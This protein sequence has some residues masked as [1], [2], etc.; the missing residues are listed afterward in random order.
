MQ[1]RR[2]RRRA[3]HG[4][5]QPV[6]QGNLGRLAHG[7][8]EQQQPG[9]D[10][11]AAV[12]CQG[13][14]DFAGARRPDEDEYRDVQAQIGAAGVEEGAA[15]GIRGLGPLE[16]EADQQVA[17]QSDQLPGRQQQY[18]VAGQHQ[19]LHRGEEQGHDGTEPGQAR[20][21]LHVADRVGQH[22]RADGGHRHGQQR[23]QRLGGQAQWHFWQA[24]QKQRFGRAAGN[25]GQK[26]QTRPQTEHGTAQG[27]RGSAPA[28]HQDGRGGEQGEQHRQQH[29]AHPF[30]SRASSISTEPLARKRAIATPK[31]TAISTAMTV[32]TTSTNIC[33]A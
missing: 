2:D 10:R 23:C 4:A 14:G 30:R 32:I 22:E 15:G 33:P 24:G 29:G 19:G 26:P 5:H 27:Q 18:P 12:R 7:G 16:P 28:Q 21:A 9:G 17:A 6:L 25:P 13:S 1:Q 20:L 3:R 31:P 11:G 8:H